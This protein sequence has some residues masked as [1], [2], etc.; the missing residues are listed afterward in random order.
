MCTKACQL[1]VCGLESCCTDLQ[2]SPAGAQE[3]NSGN[4]SSNVL[5]V[6]CTDGVK[7][8]IRGTTHYHVHVTKHVND[9]QVP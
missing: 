4:S 2:W 1:Q 6:G 3:Q 5:A 9:W 8:H 7:T